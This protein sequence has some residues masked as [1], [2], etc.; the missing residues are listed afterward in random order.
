MNA[1]IRKLGRRGSR[2]LLESLHVRI[3]P[4][5]HPGGVGTRVPGTF[6]PVRYEGTGG[7]MMR[8]DR[9]RFRLDPPRR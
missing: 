2:A 1:R 3:Q 8:V 5:S 9:P 6:E 4:G 7:E